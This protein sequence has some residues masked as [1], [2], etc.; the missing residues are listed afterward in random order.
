MYWSRGELARAVETTV[1]RAGLAV[2]SETREPT[3]TAAFGIDVTTST[4]QC[5][6]AV[7]ADVGIEVEPVSCSY[8][9]LEST[10]LRIAPAIL[11]IGDVEPRFAAVLGARG[12][13]VRLLCPDLHVRTVP[14]EVLARAL[15]RRLEA[16]V[17]SEI[18]TCLD[19]AGVSAPRRE[20][21]RRALLHERL[22]SAGIHSCYVLREAPGP[23]FVRE[24][25]RGGLVPHVVLQAAAHLAQVGILVLAW[26]IIARAVFSDHIER[27]WLLGAVTLMLS[28]IPFQL[29]E[30]WHAGVLAL[31]VGSLV[32]RRLLVGALRL[33]PEEVCVNGAGT[34]LAR[35]VEADA[36]Q[37]TILSGAA[38]AVFGFVELGLA[39]GL[40]AIGAG[41]VGHAL[42]LVS[43]SAV[44]LALLG[45]YVWQRRRWTESRL[46]MTGA[47]VERMIG[48]ATRLVQQRPLDWHSAEDE[49]LEDYAI[50][51]RRMDAALRRFAVLATRGWGLVG[52]V[53]LVPA[54]IMPQTSRGALALALGGVLLAQK[55]L[56]QLGSNVAALA[57]IVIGWRAVGEMLEAAGRKPATG[58]PAVAVQ[59][60][61]RQS[62][63]APGDVILEARDV[64]FRYPG[65]SVDVLLGC[66]LRIVR[67]DRVLLEGGSGSGKSTLGS[68]LA[69]VRLPS[70][71]ALTL[72]GLDW[73]TVG[74]E[75]WRRRVVA[76]PQFH[77]NHVFAGTL[78]YNL[79]MGRQWP[80]GAE[81]LLVAERVCHELCLGSLIERMPS[82]L[83][84]IVGES[85][86][87]LSHGEKSRVF[88]ARALLQNAEV[89]VFDESFAA[90]DPA[91]LKACIDTVLRGGQA[92][93][94]IAHP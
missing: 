4:P 7:A 43:W 47:L 31:E 36:I 83:Q 80:A 58:A 27:S 54:I 93:V 53:G 55:A 49:E 38:S 92:L 15:A 50:R 40:L 42:L 65:R 18:E 29:L 73:R 28:A 37:A 34:R 13:R 6:A 17:E 62:A 3:R 41:G 77:E 90:L 39:V 10:L 81:D 79:L 16:S 35:A 61:L 25:L 70:A 67:G 89:V 21:T 9:A 1:R 11:E 46:Q 66:D 45:R 69:G 84:T 75:E 33:E 87:Q 76:A 68:I 91:T 32:K 85:G 30:Q 2:R 60:L 74:S 48:Y 56:S 86:W 72:R 12:R 44:S 63:I 26:W 88:I 24:L 78:A 94:V 52:L 20:A 59:Q 22:A 51:S 82:G 23:S 14:V 8:A 19:A 71:G 64:R 57:D 5:L